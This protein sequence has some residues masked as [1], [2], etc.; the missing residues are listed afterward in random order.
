MKNNK[1]RCSWADKE[2]DT[3]YQQYHDLEWGVPI[4]DDHKI[5]EYLTLESAQAG[6]SWLTILRKRKNYRK[7]FMNFDVKK[8]AKFDEKKIDELM[9]N[10]GIIRYRPKIEA[11]IN[12][13]R[14]FI[15]IQK[16]FGSFSKY[17]WGFVNNKQIKNS[18]KNLEEVPSQI[19][20]SKIF[21]KDLKKRGF[22]FLGPVTCYA[23]MQASGM[24]N[25]HFIHCF[26]YSKINTLSNK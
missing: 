11:A 18:W 16:E 1:R 14:K 24:V 8:V 4:Y 5:F 17:M 25:D 9:K 26:R 23:H 6:L 10:N 3:L 13:A 22:K 20:I 19:E 7:A 2:N 21:H 15:E 12:N